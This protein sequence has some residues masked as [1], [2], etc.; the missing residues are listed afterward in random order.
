[1]KFK[2]TQ[3]TEIER[4][5]EKHGKDEVILTVYATEGGQFTYSLQCRVSR[6]IRAVFPH[7]IQDNFLTS[8]KAKA[9]AV[10]TLCAWIK[11]SRAA[12]EHLRSF[13]ITAS[14]YQLEFDFG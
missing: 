1:M 13:D 12:K 5:D 4:I 11:P 3:Q 6:I 10:E 8:A 7:Q 2:E 14:P 9:A